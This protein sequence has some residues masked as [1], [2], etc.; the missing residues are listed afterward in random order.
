M[1]VVY[2]QVMN[3]FVGA[4]VDDFFR[5]HVTRSYKKG[6][7]LLL[8]HE[9]PRSVYYVVEGRV[10][11]YGITYKGEESI[12]NIYQPKSPIF[13]IHAFTSLPNLYYFS[14]ET[15]IVIISVPYDDMLAFLNK[16][17]DVLKDL[18][19]H[20]YVGI[21]DILQRMS[22][23]L[24]GSAHERVVYEILLEIR[25]FGKTEQD[26]DSNSHTLSITETDLASRAGLSR[27]TVS[28]VISILKRKGILA[29]LSK[30]TVLD[31]ALLQKSLNKSL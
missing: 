29:S 10:K 1:K 13:L 15:D 7:I 17:P 19:V 27:E 18:L 24:G 3:I 8:A 21:D 31:I 26:E 28:R 11:Q 30:I 9:T 22:Y 2:N 20:V 4:K 25:R 23:L 16:N 12:V 5:Q 14:A 6:Q